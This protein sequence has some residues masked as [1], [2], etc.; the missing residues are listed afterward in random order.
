MAKAKTL[1]PL[2]L[3]PF[4]FCLVSAQDPKTVSRVSNYNRIAKAWNS[5]PPATVIWNREMEAAEKLLR[6]RFNPKIL[7]VDPEEKRKQTVAHYKA[8]REVLLTELDALNELIE[9][10]DY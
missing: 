6:E 4:L 3:I 7:V 8:A 1:A 5:I 10:E 9:E 2:A